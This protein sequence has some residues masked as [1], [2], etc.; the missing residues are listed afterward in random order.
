MSQIY[1]NHYD[2]LTYILMKQDSPE[3]LM[4]LCGEIYKKDNVIGGI[5]NTYYIQ[6]KQMK[7]EIGLDTNVKEHL[8]KAKEIITKYDLLKDR[9]NF[10]F[11]I[12][13]C[14]YI[15]PYHL[16]E[17]YDIGL[18]SIIPV[19]NEDNEYGGGALGNDNQGLTTMGAELIREAIRL[20]IA[21]DISHLNYKTASNVLD[22]FIQLKETGT[23]PIVLASHSNCASLTPR[24]RNI[25]DDI[26][27]KI[28]QLDGVVGIMPRKTFC[29]NQKVDDYDKAFASHIR[30]VSDLIGI[31]HVCVASDDMEYHPDKSYQEVAMYEIRHFADSVENALTNNGFSQEERQKVMT[32]NFKTK[33]LDKINR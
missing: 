5:I 19:Y 17:L 21:I 16:E 4:D 1:D 27:E 26:I 2:L 28:G 32:K 12:E 3:F 30:H 18:R 10:L 6:K 11:G 7:E 8:L 22:Y 33:V 29:S 24:A 15:A 20:N 9:E 25:P 23:S 14:T 31:D 13:G